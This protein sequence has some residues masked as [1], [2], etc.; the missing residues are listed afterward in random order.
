MNK[1]LIIIESAAIATEGS[2]LE[3]IPCYQVAQ[4]V[5]TKWRSW[6]ISTWRCTIL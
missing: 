1:M 2:S 3:Q 4:A 5:I 6:K